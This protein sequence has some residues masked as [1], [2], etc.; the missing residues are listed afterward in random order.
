METAAT[1]PAELDAL[2]KSE[3]ARYGQAIKAA[4]VKID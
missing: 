3:L 4:G 2:M 1:T